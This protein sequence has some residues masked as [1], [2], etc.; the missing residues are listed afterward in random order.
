MIEKILTALL[1]AVAAVGGRASAQE[2]AGG[3]VEVAGSLG[4]V[5]STVVEPV[6]VIDRTGEKALVIQSL[7]AQDERTVEVVPFFH[8]MK[9][10]GRARDYWGFSFGGT[11]A[12]SNDLNLFA[13]FSYHLAH[14][15]YITGGMNWKKV[16]TLPPEQKLNHEPL[17]PDIL[18][19][20]STRTEKGFFLAW[21]LA[22]MGPN[23]GLRS[24]TR[25]FDPNH[26]LTLYD[27]NGNNRI[28]CDEARAHDLVPDQNGIPSSDPVFPYMSDADQDGFVCET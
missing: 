25:N 9:Q 3:E 22:V 1:F 19:N 12:S 7:H 28:S 2:N 27:D 8:V 6:Y 16:S 11:D 4:V 10:R 15:F 20:L 14:N 17:T 18:S 26:P 24:P 5:A 23:D 13:G 21:T